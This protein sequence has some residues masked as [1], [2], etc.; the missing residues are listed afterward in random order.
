[1]AQGQ[2]NTLEG[3]FLAKLKVTDG[4]KLHNSGVGEMPCSSDSYESDSPPYCR[5]AAKAL[6]SSTHK[7]TSTILESL[8]IYYNGYFHKSP[9]DILNMINEDTGI[10]GAL[11]E[12]QNLYIEGMKNSMTFDCSN[13]DFIEIMQKKNMFTVLDKEIANI[14]DLRKEV[15]Y[16]SLVEDFI[17]A[18]K[19]M[20]THYFHFYT[21][22]IRCPAFHNPVP[23]DRFVHI[24]RTFARI[25]NLLVE[26][27]SAWKADLVLLP[28]NSD[29][30]SALYVVMVVTVFEPKSSKH[31][32]LLSNTDVENGKKNP[33]RSSEDTADNDLEVV[34]HQKPDIYSKIPQNVL[35]QHGGE[36]LIHHP[37]YKNGI[38]FNK[39]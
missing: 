23:K 37:Y 39:T 34:I 38:E 16:I 4:L 18:V 17:R 13:Q 5:N 22:S 11:T 10:F 2:S 15:L 6:P 20:L 33:K 28:D 9:M 26:P 8:G 32:Q 21:K 36:L 7:W 29:S 30:D 27:G 35:G 31:L 3:E 25:C 1:M 14:K 19:M 24:F 12:Q